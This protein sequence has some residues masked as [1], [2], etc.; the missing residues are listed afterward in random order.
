MP[1]TGRSVR[2][3]DAVEYLASLR[4]LADEIG[5]IVV[6]PKH[7]RPTD[8][9]LRWHGAVVGGLRLPDLRDAL[10]RLIRQVER[11]LGGPLHELSREDKQRA[12]QR[13]DERGAFALRKSVEGIADAMSV[14]R[15]TVY[16]YLDVIHGRDREMAR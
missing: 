12:V 9:V 11:E 2:Q 16:T 6:T 14:S 7:L 5:A 8:V 10:G 1:A 15:M 3:R 4:P 13:L